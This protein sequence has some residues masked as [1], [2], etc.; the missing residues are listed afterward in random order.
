MGNDSQEIS[1]GLEKNIDIL[2]V[3]D[4]NP[5]FV[6]ICKKTEK[7]ASALYLVTSLLSDNEP[8]RWSLRSKASDFV[9]FIISYKDIRQVE[10]QNFIDTSK[11]RV[12]EIVSL[13]E[14]ASLGGLIS[15]MNFLVLKEEFSLLVSHLQSIQK[16]DSSSSIIPSKFF[17]QSSN[18]FVSNSSVTPSLK[19]NLTVRDNSIFKSNNRQNI[20]LGLLRKKKEL[21]IKDIS[22]IIKDVS[23]KTI[24]RELISLIKA[25]V[26]L[27]SGERR[28]SKY[29][30]NIAK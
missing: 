17:D 5:D 11:T 21:S 13:L 22:T 25:G 1:R 20:I 3:F 16:T 12:F 7:L 4:D 10:L 23:E 29:S 6:F 27:K 19:D 18:Q 26:I 28:W 2:S 24:Q 15:S 14:V 8:M 30:L 9:S